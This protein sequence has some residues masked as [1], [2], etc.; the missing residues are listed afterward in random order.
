MRQ[1]HYLLCILQLFFFASSLSAQSRESIKTYGDSMYRTLSTLSDSEKKAQALLD[2]SFFWS[3]YDT[4]KAFQYIDEAKNLLGPKAKDTYYRGLLWFYRASTLFEADPERAKKAYLTS[5]NILKNLPKN[6]Q[7]IRYRIRGLGSYGALL[8]R[9]GFAEEYVSVLLEKI[10]P[11]AKGIRDSVLLGNNLQNVAM[12]MMNMQHYEKANRY[13]EE[14]LLLLQGKAHSEEQRLTLFV[15]GARNA[16]YQQDMGNAR[17]FLDSAQ[18]V[19]KVIPFSSYM[20]VYHVVE[21]SYWERKNEVGTSLEHYDKALVGAKE[22]DSRDLFPQIFY[23]RYEAFKRSRRY[24]DAKKALL[25]V[26]PYVEGKA[27]L[28]NK[29]TLYYHIAN[30]HTLTGNF[31]EATQWY[32]KFKLVSDSVF[33]HAG[34]EKI[35]GLEQKYKTAERENEL[36]LTKGKFQEQQL[37]LKRSQ[38]WLII[39]GF[40]CVLL[41]MLSLLWY[42]TL[43][44]RKKLAI[45]Q[46]L[47]LHQELKNVQQREKIS[48][49]NAMVQGQEKERSRIAR[50]LHDGL[51]GMLASVKLKL[52][53]VADEK[54][55]GQQTEETDMELYTIINQLDQS[56][57]ELRRVARNMMPESLLYMGLE[58]AL[59][60][61]CNA[62]SHKGLDIEFEARD[63][64]TDYDQSFLISV[65]RIVQ[66]LLTNAVKHSEAQKVWVQCN[67]NDGHFYLSVEDNGKGFLYHVEPETPSGIGLSNIRNRVELLNGQLEVD[68][69]IGRGA[70]FHID[71]DLNG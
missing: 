57:N 38:N 8:Q 24:E 27:L 30:L 26:L 29:Q 68:S 16:I 54:Q 56:V 65:Y 33:A 62:M 3:D 25:D 50:D 21:G 46:E 2:L 19:L 40:A 13:Y 41:A 15:N 71:I 32:E 37:S 28:R 63:L 10:I 43:R 70:S 52:S 48:V 39:M 58:A 47:L 67:E 36:L 17:K 14:A 42:T 59:R 55:F 35:L 34:E 11:M 4:V 69:V 5:D 18:T 66:E 9:E 64:R 20:P 53:A 61:L 49:F 31:R 23:G 51:G 44:N 1:V 12:A 22:L 7:A 45:Q 60:D 6:E